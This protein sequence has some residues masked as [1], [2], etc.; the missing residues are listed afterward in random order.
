MLLDEWRGFRPFTT[1]STVTLQHA[2]AIA[3]ASGAERV[4]TLGL[5][6]GYITR[7]GA[8]PLPSCDSQ[9]GERLSDPGN[10]PNAWQ[11]QMRMGWLDLVL[12][13]YAFD[14]A[15]GSLDGLAVN[16]LDELPSDCRVCKAYRL[17]DG[18]VLERLPVSDFAS[19]AHQQ[20]LAETL[21]QATPIYESISAATLSDRLADAVRPCRYPRLESDMARQ[22]D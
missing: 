17:K 10:P 3:E 21:S 1:W 7:H 8:G 11:G 13:R 15:G 6:R 20:Q 5:T 12:L 14:A 16:C 22:K 4:L 19:L 18:T 9:L 2:L